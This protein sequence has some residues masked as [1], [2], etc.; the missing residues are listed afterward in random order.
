MC[1]PQG[2]K[3]RTY[4]SLCLS[5]VLPYLLILPLKLPISHKL[6]V[7]RGELRVV[8]RRRNRLCLP[9]SLSS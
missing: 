4:G 2:A 8:V 7:L 6:S 9:I 1:N 5:W 3:I